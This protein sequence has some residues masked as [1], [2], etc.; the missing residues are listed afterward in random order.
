[1]CH[2]MMD[3][4]GCGNEGSAHVDFCVQFSGIDNFF[5]NCLLLK[6][7]QEGKWLFVTVFSPENGCL[8]LKES[9]RT[10]EATRKIQS[11]ARKQTEEELNFTLSI[12][13]FVL[14][15]LRLYR[16]RYYH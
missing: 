12:E 3:S 7:K 11:G 1:M 5:K 8:N 13:F 4:V 15:P 9:K 10:S 2:K 14:T 6:P 16:Y